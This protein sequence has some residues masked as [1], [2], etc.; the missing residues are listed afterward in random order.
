[1]SRS[2]AIGT[3]GVK[4]PFPLFTSFSKRSPVLRP[5]TASSENSHRCTSAT[6]GTSV[7]GPPREGLFFAAA[8]FVG[9]VSVYAL[10][11]VDEARSVPVTGAY[12]QAF[13]CWRF[14]TTQ[15]PNAIRPRIRPCNCGGRLSTTPSRNPPDPMRR[16]NQHSIRD[17]WRT[18]GQG[19]EL[20]HIG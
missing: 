5:L 18:A 8:S 2:S 16:I 12:V 9:N 20:R 10:L 11:S 3:G 7:A 6:S 19:D 4:M 15:L 14:L 17:R 13:D 1:M